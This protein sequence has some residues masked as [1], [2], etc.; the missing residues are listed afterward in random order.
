MNKRVKQ[1]L[2]LACAGA[3]AASLAAC[4][5]SGNQADN[6]TGGNS[7]GEPQVTLT[8]LDAFTPGDGMT[9][10]FRNVLDQF[11]KDNPNIKIDEETISSDDLATKVQ[12]LAAA[13]ELPD[14]FWL[15][16]QMAE[17]FVNNG[18]V[19]P[20]GEFLDN[21][22][23]WKASFKEGVFS[24]FTY[25]DQIYG[26]P[27]QITNTCIYY[28]EDL[29]KAAGVDQFPTTWDELLDAVKKIKATGVTPIVLGNK[30]K[31]NAESVIM[32]TLGNR[33]TG[34][35]W[36]Q[37]I[38]DKSGAKFTDPEF[39]AALS[40]LDQLAKAGAF[41]SDVNSIDDSQQ[42]Q[43]Y[44]NG[45]AAMSIDGTWALADLKANSPEDVLNATKIAALPSVEGGKGDQNAIT[46]G[47]GWAYA[48]NASSDPAKKTAV[49]KF[50][51]ALTGVEFATEEAKAGSLTAVT[52]NDYDQSSSPALF[53]EFDE[54]QKNRPF[55]PVY[56]HQLSSGLMEVLQS[57]LQELL[58]G[59]VT[60]E[61]LAQKVQDE[62]ARE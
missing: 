8:L 19:M 34:D 10:A 28:N 11:Q 40:A 31:W 60:P 50:L 61:Q 55:I 2:S 53:K 16:G 56:D 62:Y 5:N 26:I 24:N 49:G 52:P 1:T 30:A 21:D 27:F 20:L 9:T 13:D 51:R 14:I 39:V 35:E 4:G 37:N 29:M 12:T 44:M 15:K 33:F 42:R 3:L 22:P 18:K 47:A 45:Q 32:S 7:G 46:G 58:I 6:G 59:V 17:T 41:N 43:L 23:D 57:G 25:N 38:R 48:V 54:F 36:Y